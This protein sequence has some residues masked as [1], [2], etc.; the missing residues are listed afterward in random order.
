VIGSADLTLPPPA[1][2]AYRVYPS[3]KEELVRGAQLSEVPVRAWK[4]VVA[5]SKTATVFNFLAST[6]GYLEH[7]VSGVDEGFVPSSGVE[8]SVTS[9]DLLFKELDVVPST[10]GLRARPLVPPPTGK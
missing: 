7:K 3:G 8:S 9:P 5:G 10:L 2:L 4:D 6:E 1:I